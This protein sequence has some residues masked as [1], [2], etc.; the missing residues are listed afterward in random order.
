MYDLCVLYGHRSVRG[1]SMAT[2]RSP[3]CARIFLVGVRLL[4]WR[5]REFLVVLCEEEILGG[6]V[7]CEG[8]QCMRS[9]F[10]RGYSWSV[11]GCCAREFMVAV[12]CTREFNVCGRLSCEGIHGFGGCVLYGC[13]VLYGSVRCEKMVAVP[14]EEIQ[15]TNV[16][17]VFVCVV[18]I[19]LVFTFLWVFTRG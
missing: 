14:C 7:L 11:F 1:N 10:V 19:C 4:C 12:F 17:S 15:C 9:P 16:L 5:A 13:R 18:S 8:I 2:V 6:R 3:F